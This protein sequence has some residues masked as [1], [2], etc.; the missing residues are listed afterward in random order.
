MAL[1]FLENLFPPIPSE[2][3][4]PLAGFVAARGQMSLILALIAGVVGTLLG[5]VFW[6][7]LSRAIGA[8]RI[9]PL[10][11]R[12]GR[13]FAVGEEDLRKAEA[14]LEKYGP[15]AL[16]F[17]RL[18]PGHPHR[19]L[20]PCRAD[21]HSAPG[22]L[23]VDRAGQWRLDHLPDAGRLFH[24]R[25]LRP[26]RGL[27]GNRWP[28]SSSAASSRPISGTSGRRGCASAEAWDPP[29]AQGRPG[30]RFGQQ[31]DGHAELHR[32]EGQ[33]EKAPEQRCRPPMPGRPQ[34]QRPCIAGVGGQKSQNG[35][36]GKAE[37]H[38]HLKQHEAD[39][40]RQALPASHGGASE[41][42]PLQRRAPGGGSARKRKGPGSF[43]PWPFAGN[44]AK[45]Q[46]RRPRRPIRVS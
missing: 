6:Y 40:P 3:I 44:V 9:R 37:A 43:P 16:S 14:T 22:L 30:R 28:M 23:P 19:H 2:V 1:M 35:Q 13:W 45:D 33:A 11:G 10:V 5:N 12:Y 21:P 20:H 36:S 17:G 29:A 32:A 27:A 34:Q 18:L 26:D 24:G 38:Q 42:Q 4:M 46:R 39:Q 41:D 7:E 15:F 25:P 8:D 31:G